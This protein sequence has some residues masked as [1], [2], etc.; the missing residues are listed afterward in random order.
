MRHIREEEFGLWWPKLDQ[1]IEEMVKTCEPC[2]LS[3][4][5]PAVAP[6]HPWEFPKQLW[7]R[8]HID[9]AGLFL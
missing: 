2:Q 6:L 7:S 9:Y 5:L 4:P 8:L 1:V 3:Y